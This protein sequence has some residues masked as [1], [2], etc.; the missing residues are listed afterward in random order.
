MLVGRSIFYQKKIYNAE[1]TDVD[2]RTK[3]VHEGFVHVVF[4]D[5]VTTDVINGLQFDVIGS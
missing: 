4:Q 2:I 1:K 5:T 3:G